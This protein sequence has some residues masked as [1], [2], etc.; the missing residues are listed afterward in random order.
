MAK[1]TDREPTDDILLWTL[2][3]LPIANACFG[4]ESPTV[5]IR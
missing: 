3:R 4:V 5:W 2:S 1:A